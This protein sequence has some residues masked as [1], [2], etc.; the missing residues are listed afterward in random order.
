MEN[1]WSWLGKVGVKEGT[2]NLVPWLYAYSLT[3]RNEIM[4]ICFSAEFH[5]AYWAPMPNV[6]LVRCGAL[7]TK[8]CFDNSKGTLATLKL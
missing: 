7:V 6:K 3:K 1:V 2:S 4:H 5:D 8:G